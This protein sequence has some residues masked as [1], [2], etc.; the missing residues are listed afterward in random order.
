M[1]SFTRRLAMKWCLRHPKHPANEEASRGKPFYH[2]HLD[3]S[4]AGRPVSE[5]NSAEDQPPNFAQQAPCFSVHV[6]PNSEAP[7]HRLPTEVLLDI[8][9]NATPCSRAC[10]ALSSKRLFCVISDGFSTIFD[11][12]RLPAELPEEAPSYIVAKD[13][14]L[15]YQPEGGTSFLSCKKILDSGWPAQ[16]VLSCIQRSGLGR[17]SLPRG[18]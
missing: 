5:K 2:P 7:I 17:Q 16:T 8:A 6:P 10:L 11:E 14:P 15:M 18:L 1:P 3:T 9:S 4:R 13:W 12:L